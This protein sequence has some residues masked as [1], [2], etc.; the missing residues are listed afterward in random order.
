MKCLTRMIPQFLRW[1]LFYK[2]TKKSRV[3]LVCRLIANL[4]NE[5]RYTRTVL[6]GNE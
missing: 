3:E 6:G 1:E 5:T 2:R 4:F